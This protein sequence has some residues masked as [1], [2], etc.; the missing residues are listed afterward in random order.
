[1]CDSLTQIWLSYYELIN[2]YR[3][4]CESEKCF[5]Q[6]NSVS[7]SLP[8]SLWMWLWLCRDASASCL[9]M[10]C[11]AC[12]RGRN[13]DI[14]DRSWL[15]G[16]TEP[17]IFPTQPRFRP[18]RRLWRKKLHRCRVFRSYSVALFST[19]LALSFPL[20]FSLALACSLSLSLTV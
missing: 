8:S 3:S 15:T 14:S 13:K 7:I 5:I 11:S 10:M 17:L 9:I 2:S 18:S 12:V 20:S 16:A 1:M 6:I 4:I 19:A